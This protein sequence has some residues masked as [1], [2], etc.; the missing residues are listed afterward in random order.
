MSKHRLVVNRI[1]DIQCVSR[2]IL[3]HD[4]GAQDAVVHV[5]RMVI[6]CAL[7]LERVVVTNI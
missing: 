3:R 4:V 1:I 7:P 5:V 2:K 6:E